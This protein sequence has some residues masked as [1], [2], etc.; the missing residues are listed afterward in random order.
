MTDLHDIHTPPPLGWID[1]DDHINQLLEY[2]IKYREWRE[3]LEEFAKNLRA[4]FNN[5]LTPLSVT[6]IDQK[7]EVPKDLQIWMIK[8][9]TTKNDKTWAVL[10]KALIS[11]LEEMKKKGAKQKA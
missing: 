8:H 3:R 7:I 4:Q 9:E 1:R 6:F 5:Q 2:D 11:K 10:H